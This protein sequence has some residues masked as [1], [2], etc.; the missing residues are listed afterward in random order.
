MDDWRNWLQQSLQNNRQENLRSLNTIYEANTGLTTGLTKEN[1][2]STK[3][4]DVEGER[5][6]SA[7]QQGGETGRLKRKAPSE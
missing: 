5:E 7:D 1:E 3:N 4:V 6:I 2:L